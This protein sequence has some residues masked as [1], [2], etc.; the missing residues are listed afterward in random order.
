MYW[1][2][3]LIGVLALIGLPFV[4]KAMFSSVTRKLERLLEETKRDGAIIHAKCMFREGAIESPGVVQVVDGRLFLIGLVKSKRFSIPLSEISLRKEA[5]WWST[6][7]RF[8]RYAFH[9]DSPQSTKLIIAVNDPQQ[10]R[11]IFGET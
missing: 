6:G 3:G 10:W 11:R 9:L 4:L 2:W 1:I 8:G 5:R 7:R